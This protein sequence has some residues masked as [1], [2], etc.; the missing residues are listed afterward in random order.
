M[1]LLKN[2][3]MIY[4]M[5]IQNLNNNKI[6][7]PSNIYKFKQF[8]KQLF[9]NFIISIQQSQH[10]YQN[11]CFS[12]YVFLKGGF[13]CEGNMNMPLQ[14][15]LCLFINLCSYFQNQQLLKFKNQIIQNA[16]SLIYK[17]VVDIKQIRILQKISIWNY[18]SQIGQLEKL[19]LK[20]ELRDIS[21]Q[22]IGNQILVPKLIVIFPERFYSV[23][24]S[25]KFI[26]F[27]QYNII[28]LLQYKETSFN[29]NREKKDNLKFVDINLIDQ[30]IHQY[31]NLLEQNFENNKININYQI[32]IQIK[33]LNLLYLNYKQQ[34]CF[35]YTQN[36]QLS[37]TISGINEEI[38]RNKFLKKSII[39]FTHSIK[40][41]Q[42][43]NQI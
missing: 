8:T 7:Y 13:R 17:I 23:V 10:N 6:N 9:D 16:V 35:K 12:G 1:I 42:I 11:L 30:M 29:E 40:I 25:Q 14:E 36:Q 19:I 21:Q 26:S 31:E 2:I 41:I 3:D 5:I 37:K 15:T 28:R 38:K 20:V 4:N 22:I 27:H 39:Y 43:S 34:F 18:F 33:L 24:L 32:I